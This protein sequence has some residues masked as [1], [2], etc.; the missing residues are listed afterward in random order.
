ME[1]AD[2][3]I[4]ESSSTFAH[5]W[6][7]YSSW[8]NYTSPTPTSV[9][10]FDWVI[11]D[12]KTKTHGTTTTGGYDEWGDLSETKNWTRADDLYESVSKEGW[13]YSDGRKG[14][15]TYISHTE[16][17]HRDDGPAHGLQYDETIGWHTDQVAPGGFGD[18]WP[19]EA[20]GYFQHAT[21]ADGAPH[22]PLTNHAP[23][24]GQGAVS[25]QHYLLDTI[26]TA[27]FLLNDGKVP[28]GWRLLLK[29]G[30]WQEDLGDSIREQ[31]DFEAQNIKDITS[32][33][34]GPVGNG[35]AG[36]GALRANLHRQVMGSLA[37]MI[38]LP[39]TAE[40]VIGRSIDSAIV[41]DQYG[42]L[43]GVSHFIGTDGIAEWMYNVDLLT[44]KELEE[45]EG[46]HRLAQGIGASSGVVLTIGG[47]YLLFAAP[48][49]VPVELEGPS[50]A[51]RVFRV[52]GDPN[53][54]IILGQ[55]GTVAIQGD[56]TLFLNFG[57]QARAEE[58]LAQRLRQAMPGATV[59]SFE[60]PQSVLTELQEAGVPESLARQFPDRPII[61]DPTKAP[62]Q[63]G[64]RENMLDWF[65]QQIMVGSGRE[66]F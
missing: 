7:E 33:L 57:E 15:I 52:E 14:L 53:T 61:V 18:I 46:I 50:S 63:F 48:K 43:T 25:R 27:A 65:Q 47:T 35:I 29:V 21:G 36:Y 60:V 12:W 20:A 19:G 23:L 30:R 17:H 59:K 38:D 28:L 58:F 42:P 54:R 11:D 44:G 40:A 64:L 24:P 22:D 34:D 32:G 26:D 8:V 62:N 66:G 45:G 37:G 2:Y 31:S 41:G 1:R 13:E 4:V 9:F 56:K 49:V 55:G 16:T 39:G 6:D 51:V 10:V 3:T 5:N